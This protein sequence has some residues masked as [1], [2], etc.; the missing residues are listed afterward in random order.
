[1]PDGIVVTPGPVE[2]ALEAS[3]GELGA[4][5]PAFELPEEYKPY[6]KF[7]W[8]DIPEGVREK[9]LSSVKEFHGG[10]TKHQQELAQLR[11]EVPQLRERTQILDNLIHEPWFKEAWDA[12]QKGGKP[13]EPLPNL[14]DQFDPDQAG[15]LER[16]IE[17]K[18]QERLNPVAE[19]LTGLQQQ[20]MNAQA[21]AEMDRLQA[22]AKAKGWPDPY[23]R[24][25]DL[26]AQVS[27]GAAQ[28]VEQAYQLSIF[29]ELEGIIKAQAQKE[30]MEGLQQK[31]ERTVPPTRSPGGT[32]GEQVFKGRDAVRHALEASLKEL[33]GG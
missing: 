13:N 17:Q 33:A 25:N 5:Q 10:M 15:V 28:T 19:R 12:H 2:S 11:N 24:V 4:S 23:E 9:V 16:I 26:Y 1:M 8:E 21:K 14:T 31:A 18:V 27:S 30:T 29:P 20:Q 7:P 22:E 6:S 32:P 3:A